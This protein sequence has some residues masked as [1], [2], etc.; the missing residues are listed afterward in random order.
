MVPKPLKRFSPG[1]RDVLISKHLRSAAARIPAARL[2]HRARC[3][4]AA[5]LQAAVHRA[6][7]SLRARFKPLVDRALDNVKLMPANP[8]E[9]VARKMLVD[10]ILDRVVERGFLSMG[11]LRDALSRNNLKLP[12]LASV[13]QFL[14]GDQ[15]LQADQQLATSLDGVYRAG[16]VYLRFPQRLS[17]LAFGTPLGRFLTPYVALPFGVASVPLEGLQHL[18]E[19]VV[20]CFSV[21]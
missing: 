3:R 10:E 8:P 17:S 19:P 4:L 15:L 13:Q 6:E 7:A 1:Q 16:E 2:S 11:D 20:D 12:D 9:Q 14:Q 21:P 5:L 18:A